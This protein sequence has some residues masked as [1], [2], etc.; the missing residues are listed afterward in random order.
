MIYK[1]KQLFD[2][3]YERVY[4]K[5]MKLKQALILTMMML[6]MAAF[7]QDEVHE[8]DSEKEILRELDQIHSMGSN[9]WSQKLEEARLNSYEIE[10]EENL[11]V[12]LT[13]SL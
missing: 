8:I 1:L 9:K 10:T 12:H 7:A 6:S 4:L 5:L 3:P 11:P 13:E 2:F